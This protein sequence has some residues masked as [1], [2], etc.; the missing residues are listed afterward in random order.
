MCGFIGY[1]GKDKKDLRECAKI[2]SHRGP[3]KTSIEQNENFSVA[4]NRLSIIDIS[5]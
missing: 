4:F 2:I 1:I 3:D 5:R